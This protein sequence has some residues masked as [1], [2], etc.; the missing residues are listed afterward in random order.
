MLGTRTHY[1]AKQRIPVWLGNAIEAI[2]LVIGIFSL[3]L[4]N[5]S[6]HL[7]LKLTLLLVAWFCFWFFS[8]CLTHFIVGKIIGVRFLYYF[9]GRSGL[10]KLNLP[11]ISFHAR[12]FPVL[13]IK[14]DKASFNSVSPKKQAVVFASGALASMISP[15][16]IMVYAIMYL[17][18]WIGFFTT[19]VTIGNIVFTLI[20][21]SKV[22]DIFKAKRAL[23]SS[24]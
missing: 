22:G 15:I 11:I 5:Q 17:E 23:N 8:H 14:I 2:G 19:F 13:G 24:H 12:I 4:V 1:Y 9:I 7:L 20:F 3:L 6:F 10:T 18:M 16:T 21:S